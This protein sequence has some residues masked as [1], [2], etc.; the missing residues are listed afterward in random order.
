MD[1]IGQLIVVVQPLFYKLPCVKE[2]EHF[3]LFRNSSSHY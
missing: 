2:Q 3:S 1:E